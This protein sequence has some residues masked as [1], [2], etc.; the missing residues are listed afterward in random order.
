VESEGKTVMGELWVVEDTRPVYP[1]QVETPEEE[2]EE[3]ED[4]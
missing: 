1:Q 2:E 3:E 4:K